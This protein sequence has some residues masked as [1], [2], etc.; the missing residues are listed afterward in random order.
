MSSFSALFFDG[1]EGG[2]ASVAYGDPGIGASGCPRSYASGETLDDPG[3]YFSP[4]TERLRTCLPDRAG[5]GC[6]E[7]FGEGD[8]L[9][10]DPLG[11]VVGRE[12]D[13]DR[14]RI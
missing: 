6:G 1:L 7:G 14:L 13:C 4:D 10:V 11:E 3:L 5:L 2:D 8:L 12:V 9:D